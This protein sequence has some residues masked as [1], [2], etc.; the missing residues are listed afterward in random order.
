MLFSLTLLLFEKSK[1]PCPVSN[2]LIVV[3]FVQRDDLNE[4]DFPICFSQ[5]D[6]WD[7]WR[8]NSIRR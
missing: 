5:R 1:K 3:L 7:K 4:F 6:N 8:A 2:I